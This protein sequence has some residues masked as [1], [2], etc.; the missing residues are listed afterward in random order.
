MTRNRIDEMLAANGRFQ[1]QINVD[2]LPKRAPEPLAV[3]T[4]MDPRLNL[5]AIGIP[6]FSPDGTG[7]SD[8]RIIRTIGGMV[9]ARS[10]IVGA[11]LAGIREFALLMHTDCGCCLAYAKIDTIIDNMETRLTFAQLQRFK[12]QIGEPFR[13][14]LMTYLKVFEDPRQAIQRELKDI[15]A[16]SYVPDDIVLHGLLYDTGTGE[17]QVVSNGYE[18]YTPRS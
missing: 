2:N 10:L 4:C 11:F 17:V 13:A 15:R 1:A 12:Q 3:I 7:H 14:N 5:E 8:I 6:P 16:Q 18:S 9:E